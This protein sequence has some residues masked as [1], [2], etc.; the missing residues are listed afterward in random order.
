MRSIGR[1]NWELQFDNDSKHKSKLTQEY[2]KKHKI[3]TLEWLPYF[4]DLNPIKN[5][6]VLWQ[7][8]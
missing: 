7:E 6:W 4:P 1:K 8:N 5:T 2:L 3:A